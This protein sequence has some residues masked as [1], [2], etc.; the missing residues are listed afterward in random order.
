MAEEQGKEE[1]TKEV[2]KKV[3]LYGG[4]FDP[5]HYGHLNLA[6]ELLELCGLDEVWFC[7]AQSNPHKTEDPAAQAVHRLKMIQLAIE[8][9][10][11]FKVIDSEIK[12]PA[13]SYTIDTLKELKEQNPTTV[14][15]LLLGEDSV[16][17]FFRWR[18]PLAILQLANVH[19]G[20]RTG[21]VDSN[22][23]GGEDQA[24]LQAIRQGM[25]QTR[26]MDICSTMIRDRLG[27]GLYCGHLLPAKVID[28]I[29][30]NQLYFPK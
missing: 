23:Y 12:R 1:Q 6:V 18:E 22:R 4:T 27:R 29:K 28:Y 19:V 30:H 17:G 10:P 9:I 20:S 3:G 7:P 25:T 15:S 16:S 5:I 2:Q 24:I 13:P 8:E 11:Y 26:L 21:E 14:F